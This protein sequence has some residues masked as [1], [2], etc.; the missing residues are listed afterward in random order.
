ME[1]SGL[2]LQHFIGM[3][4]FPRNCQWMKLEIDN[5][6]KIVFGNRFI[7][8]HS[9]SSLDIKFFLFFFLFVLYVSLNLSDGVFEGKNY[10]SHKM[11][12]IG[13]WR[14]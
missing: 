10:F 12:K 11:R 6:E 5:F 14:S 13:P 4:N 1:C 3:G 7:S 2:C 9:G 8:L